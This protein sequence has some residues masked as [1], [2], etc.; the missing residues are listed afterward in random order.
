LPPREGAVPIRLLKL[1]VLVA[2]GLVAALGILTACSVGVGYRIPGTPFSV[3]AS[4]PLSRG[5]SAAKVRYLSLPV[6]SQPSGAELY[7]NGNLMGS[8]PM[9]VAIP[10]EKRWFGRA[11]G[12][13]HVLV[14][15]P[16]YMPEGRHVF[17]SGKHISATEGGPPLGTLEVRLR[18]TG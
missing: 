11:R 4:V 7:V 2:L 10:F 3:G 18:P 15:L 13:A 5:S 9:T 16:G 1:P 8:T 14:Q 6:E 17:A 12:T